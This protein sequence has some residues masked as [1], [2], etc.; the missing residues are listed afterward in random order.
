[1]P[2][3]VQWG[4]TIL[5]ETLVVLSC[6]GLSYFGKLKFCFC[7]IWNWYKMLIYLAQKEWKLSFGSK[8]IIIYTVRI[9]H[10]GLIGEFS[11]NISDLGTLL[12]AFWTW[13]EKA[14]QKPRK[15]SFMKCRIYTLDSPCQDCRK[16]EN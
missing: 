3:G 4:F 10:K 14:T 5:V 16:I 6:M 1:M 9:K 15:F 11:E 12:R 7:H 8:V 2:N 13:F